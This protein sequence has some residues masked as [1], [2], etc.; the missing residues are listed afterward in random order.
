M[1]KNIN[2][3]LKALFLGVLLFSLNACEKKKTEL[4]AQEW[5]ATELDFAGATLSGEQVSL[6]YNFKN[7]GTFERTED[8]VKEN[9][10]WTISEDG[11]KLMLEFKG[12]EGKIEKDIKELTETKLVI[13]GKEHTMLRVEKLQAK[14]SDT[15]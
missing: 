9:G 4:L 3:S 7:D 13:E 12:A 11:K 10:K 8:G 6:V 15:K 14:G 2:T 5:N 1:M